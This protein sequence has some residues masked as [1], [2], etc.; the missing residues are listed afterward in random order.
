MGATSTAGAPPASAPCTELVCLSQSLRVSRSEHLGKALVK[1]RT[2][3]R[4]HARDQISTRG[5]AAQVGK[6]GG[7]GTRGGIVLRHSNARLE[8][9]TAVPPDEGG[10]QVSSVSSVAISVTQ[11][12]G[13]RF[14]QQCHQPAGTK[15]NQWQS[16]AIGGNQWQSV[17]PARWYEEQSVAISGNQCHQPAGTKSNQWQS[18][19][20]SVTS[21]LVRRA[22]SGNQWQ[23]VS[24]A[25]WYEEQ[26]VAISG[27]QWQSVA[28]S[29]NQCHQPAGTKSNQWQSV[30]ISGKQCHQ[31]AGTK[32]N[33]WQSVAFS[34]NQ[35][36]SVAISG[37]QCHQPAGT[38]SNSPG[39]RVTSRGLRDGGASNLSLDSNE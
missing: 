5:A 21:P 36:Q 10:H 1:V 4:G 37:N 2:E 15:S 38:K 25:R 29:G 14:K 18:V 7:S 32:S 19:A 31:P 28:I 23:A 22:I 24:P 16:V 20:I 39:P 6:D 3:K 17:S 35:W 30:A 33:Q 26:S 13:S 11:L 8:V 12:S 34:G 27:I 9:Q